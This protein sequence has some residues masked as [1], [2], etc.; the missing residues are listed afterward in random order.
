MVPFKNTCP[1]KNN[2]HTAMLME[3]KKVMALGKQG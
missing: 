2:P 1:A 3:G